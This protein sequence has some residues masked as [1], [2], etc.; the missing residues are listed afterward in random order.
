MTRIK[1]TTQKQ[2]PAPFVVLSLRHPHI[3]AE[4]HNVPAQIDTGAD[5]TVIP[6]AVA[7]KLGLYAT[8]TVDVVGVGGIRTTMDLYD[9]ELTI[10]GTPPVRLEA[11]AHAG[12]PW[13]LLGRDVLNS[14]RLIL[15]GPA[16]VL[17]FG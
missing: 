3:G 12:E 5:Q 8:G 10:P 15:D 2:P 6:L 1:Y 13:V 14:Y 17:E 16:L 7:T 4:G 11:M 9:L